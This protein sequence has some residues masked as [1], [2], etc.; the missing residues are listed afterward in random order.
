MKYIAKTTS[1]GTIQA[2]LLLFPNKH[3]SRA[4]ASIYKEGKVSIEINHL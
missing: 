3:S 2:V 1:N 4:N